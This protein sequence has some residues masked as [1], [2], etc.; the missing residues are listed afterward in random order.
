MHFNVRVQCALLT[1]R[2]HQQTAILNKIIND[3]QFQGITF[4]IAFNISDPERKK[5]ILFPIFKVRTVPKSSGM[6]RKFVLFSFSISFSFL[7]WRKKK[8][9]AFRFVDKCHRI[10]Q[11]KFLEK[12]R[13]SIP[14]GFAIE[15]EIA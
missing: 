12:N 13:H 1:F 4:V 7:S 11:F 10:H 2:C 14:F 8:N 15:D 6:S 5:I 3:R 9:G